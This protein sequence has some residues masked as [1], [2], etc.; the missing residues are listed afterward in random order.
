M[1]MYFRDA[2]RMVNK[3][4]VEMSRKSRPLVSLYDCYYNDITQ[5]RFNSLLTST[6]SQELT[7]GSELYAVFWGQMNE[8]MDERRIDFGTPLYLYR[9]RFAEVIDTLDD[10]SVYAGSIRVGIDR[11]GESQFTPAESL[12]VVLYDK[13]LNVLAK[14]AP[15][16]LSSGNIRQRIGDFAKDALLF[17]DRPY[18]RGAVYLYMVAAWASEKYQRDFYPSFYRPN[19]RRVSNTYL[20]RGS[21]QSACHD[22]I[23][24]MAPEALSDL[25]VGERFEA[26]PVRCPGG[27][28]L[29]RIENNYSFTTLPSELGEALKHLI[30]TGYEEPSFSCINHGTVPQSNGTEQNLIE[31]ESE[32]DASAMEELARFRYWSTLDVR[33]SGDYETLILEKQEKP[34]DIPFGIVI[35]ECVAVPLPHRINPLIE[36]RVNGTLIHSYKYREDARYSRLKERAGMTSLWAKLHYDDDDTPYLNIIWKLR[37]DD[38]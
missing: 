21:Y 25:A 5:H 15:K 6:T 36:L 18:R 14:I 35:V 8:M 24:V 26:V 29:T 16:D 3:E 7:S 37:S 28:G 22:F 13:K 27:V 38:E 1:A 20:Y 9:F 10:G 12:D 33:F 4:L 31:V 11:I 32:H 30:S 19:E 34:Y 23:E 17:C 2:Q